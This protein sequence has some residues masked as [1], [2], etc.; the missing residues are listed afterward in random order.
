MDQ[1]RNKTSCVSCRILRRGVC[2]GLSVIPTESL[3]NRFSIWN[4]KKQS[5]SHETNLETTI[6]IASGS[7][8]I[9]LKEEIIKEHKKDALFY[10]GQ[11]QRQHTT[12][13]AKKSDKGQ[14]GG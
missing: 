12:P 8:G 9:R 1:R 14:L 3:L 5:C 2:I 6:E 7:H 13:I 10:F 11:N 4:L